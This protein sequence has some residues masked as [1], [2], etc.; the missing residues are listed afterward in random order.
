[1]FTYII[2]TNEEY[3]DIFDIHINRLHKHYPAIIPYIATN[4]K[5]SIIDK[6]DF[7]KEDHIIEYD[8]SNPH[9][10][11]LNFILQH[12][13][14]KYVLWMH[15]NN[16]LVGDIDSNVINTIVDEMEQKNIDQVRL[17]TSGI[18][19]PVFDGPL[20]KRI[21]SGYFMS[22]ASALWKTST[23]LDISSTFYHK[24]YRNIEDN[25]VQSY[26][27]KYNN[28]YL[29]SP[30][31]ILFTNEGHYLSHYFK[32]CHCTGHGKWTNSTP[33]NKMFINEMANEYGI[34]L[35][36]RGTFIP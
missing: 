19:N 8:A 14:T 20:L 23:L 13:K 6:Y 32:I 34:D 24:M 2:Y 29:S 22:V 26:V 33:M 3:N 25:D 12:I 7:I 1:M 4:Y 36:I 18:D 31:D 30:N 11:K 9:G 10:A 27:S 15:D 17:F 5:K 28:Y 16:I 21:H 35:S